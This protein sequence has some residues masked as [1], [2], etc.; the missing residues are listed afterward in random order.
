MP[1]TVPPAS[2]RLTAIPRLSG[3][4]RWRVE[5]MRSLDEACF[6]W[7]TKGQGRITISGQTRG[8]TAHNG[9]FIP[10]GVMHGFEVG[11]QVFGTAVFFGDD[12]SNDL[13]KTPLHLRIREVQAQQELNTTLDAIQRELDSDQPGN[14][15]A[16]QAYIALLSVWI[17]RQARRM[18]EEGQKND[19]SRKLVA[20]FTAL[21]EQTFR[22]GAGVGDLAAQLGVTATHLTRCCRQTC[23][24]SAIELLQDR[25]IFEARKLLAETNLPIHAIGTSL[26]FTSAAYFT[27]AFQNRTG[28][29]P[30]EF[31]RNL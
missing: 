18:G 28:T 3:G 4:E 31:R 14:R 12:E 24:R 1:K 5:A 7:F 23:D 30:R 13:P 29:S 8:Y 10:K 26:G 19:A 11:A 15:R 27:R 2:L 21:M 20:R 9:I 25:R 22:S 6:L 16:A 17:E